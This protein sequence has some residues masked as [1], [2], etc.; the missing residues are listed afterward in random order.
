MGKIGKLE[1]NNN[2]YKLKSR[3]EHPKMVASY[4][5]FVGRHSRTITP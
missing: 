4:V 5:K 2:Y 3:M 1:Q